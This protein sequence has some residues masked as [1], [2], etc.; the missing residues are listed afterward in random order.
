MGKTRAGAA[1]RG[2][3]QPPY[4]HS[5]FDELK[6]QLFGT[7]SEDCT[8]SRLELSACFLIC[9]KE[10]LPDIVTDMLQLDKQELMHVLESFEDKMAK[11]G[12]KLPKT[13]MEMQPIVQ[14]YCKYDELL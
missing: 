5:M 13:Y 11:C 2:I 4:Y 8:L 7:D 10:Y 9:T 14:A 3:K 12:H 6:L 1:I